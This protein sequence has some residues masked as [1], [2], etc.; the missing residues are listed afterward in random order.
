[1]DDALRVIS[2]SMNHICA[3]RLQPNLV[4][5][6]EHLAQHGEL[7]VNRRL[8]EQLDKISVSTVR[9]I[10]QRVGQDQPRLVRKSPTPRSRFQLGG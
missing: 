10:L 3:E 7:M 8:L 1:M 6:A 5:L 9:R 2:E 4:W